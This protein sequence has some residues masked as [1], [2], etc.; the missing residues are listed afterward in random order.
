MIPVEVDAE[1]LMSA[2]ADLAARTREASGLL[3]SFECP[4]PVPVNDNTTATHLYYIAQ[5]A[6]TNALKHGRP[7]RIEIGLRK[8]NGRLVQ[9]VRDDGDGLPRAPVESGGMGLRIMRYRATVINA[10]LTCG[11]ADGGGTLVRCVLVEGVNDAA[12][13]EGVQYTSGA[14]P[15]RG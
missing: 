3:C 15:D 11:A 10:E 12:A 2:L 4:A 9:T 14:G 8:D 7:S 6:V 5:E 13:K 1:G